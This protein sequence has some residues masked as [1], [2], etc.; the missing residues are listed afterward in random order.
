[1]RYDACLSHSFDHKDSRYT[2][3]P[4][5]IVEEARR[6]KIQVS[7]TR[8]APA[9]L[10]ICAAYSS[11]QFSEQSMDQYA[12]SSTNERLEDAENLGAEKIHM[13]TFEV[14]MT[15]YLDEILDK[16]DS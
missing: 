12:I 5:E 1:M 9:T 8:R 14:S 6:H 13:C 16:P 3:V 7:R 15:G 11:D 10:R 4:E 2:S